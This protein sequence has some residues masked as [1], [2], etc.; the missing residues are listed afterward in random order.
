MSRTLKGNMTGRAAATHKKDVRDSI[1]ART[2]RDDMLDD[3][4]RMVADKGKF[5]IWYDRVYHWR[6]IGEQKTYEAKIR[7]KYRYMLDKKKKSES[8]P[9]CPNTSGMPPLQASNTIDAYLSGNW[10]R[11]PEQVL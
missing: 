5:D 10:D 3:I 6:R 4:K 1:Y 2:W 7:R 9:P 8:L 11:I